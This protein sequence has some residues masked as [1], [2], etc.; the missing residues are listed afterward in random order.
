M[1]KVGQPIDLTLAIPHDLDD[2][3]E[4]LSATI[5]YMKPDGTEGT[6]SGCSFNK[7]AESVRGIV[8]AEENDQINTWSFIS[9][10][11]MQDGSVYYGDDYFLPIYPKHRRR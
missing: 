10:V 4:A 9:I 6:L 8:S 3:S 7:T 5:G 11:T 1:I 2:L